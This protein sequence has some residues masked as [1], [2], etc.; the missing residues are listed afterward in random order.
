[1]PVI[2]VE[3][4]SL[5]MEQK[6]GLASELTDVAAR[7]LGLP[8][9]TIYVFLKE[10]PLQY[11]ATVGSDG[12]PKV[13]PFQLLFHEGG[14]LYDCTG[15]KKEVYAE[16]CQPPCPEICTSTMNRRLRIRGRAVWTE[17]LLAKQRALAVNPLVRSIYRTADNPD[18]KVFF[19]ADAEAVL[20][21]F[22][23]SERTR[24]NSFGTERR[25]NEN[26][27]DRQLRPGGGRG[28][29]GG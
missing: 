25:Q 8:E 16:L 28:R 2:T 4:A 1:M 5:D 14:T 18:L 21:D 3:A 11:C 6:R 24:L 17:E 12:K 19:I 15:A 29:S 9:E 10:N 20:A 13:R 27:C 23:A 26:T 7:I 22:T